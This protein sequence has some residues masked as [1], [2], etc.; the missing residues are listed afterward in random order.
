[1][2]CSQRSTILVWLSS[3]GMKK[4]KMAS[5]PPLTLALL[6][7]GFT[8]PYGLSTENKAVLIRSYYPSDGGDAGGSIRSLCAVI[9]YLK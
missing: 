5:A 4:T 9:S 7:R 6:S 3:S 1:M 8:F 2:M